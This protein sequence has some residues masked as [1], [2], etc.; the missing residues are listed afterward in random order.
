MKMTDNKKAHYL[1]HRKRLRERY[2]S[3]GVK[4]LND[5]E[6]LELLLTYTRVQKDLKPLAKELLKKFKGFKGVFDTQIDDLLEVNGIGEQSAILLKLVKDICNLY[7]KEKHL[8][9]KSI[10][11]PDDITDYLRVSIGSIKDEQFMTLFLNSKNEVVAEETIGYGTVDHAVVYPRKVFENALKHKA[12]SMILVH[13]HP[14]GSLDPSSH[15]IEITKKLKTAADSL[16]IKIHDH[17]I[18]TK[19]GVLS[20][21]EK[22]LI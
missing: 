6:V 7:L 19:N 3:G 21:Y 14:G 4:S 9:N 11:S 13:N 5:Y 17:L 20:F 10:N 12:V 2:V 1:G 15:D 22:G 16:G 18:V 8:K